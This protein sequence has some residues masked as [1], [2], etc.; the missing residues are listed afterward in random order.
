MKLENQIP[1]PSNKVEPHCN[2]VGWI[3]YNDETEEYTLECY[4]DSG[5]DDIDMVLVYTHTF[6]NPY[7]DLEG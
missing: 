7:L 3:T 6:K 1:I 2:P 4:C 5:T